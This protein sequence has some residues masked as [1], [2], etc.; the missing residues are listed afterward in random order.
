L[1]GNIG[2]LRNQVALNVKAGAEAYGRTFAIMY[3]ISGYPTATLFSALTNDWSYLVNTQSVTNSPAYLR[4]KGKPVVA[5]WGFGFS[6]RSDTPAQCIQTV[7]WFKSAGCTVMGGVPSYWR[8]LTNDSQTDP[9][10]TNA[11]RSFDIISPWAVGRYSDNAG[12]DTYRTN[13]TVPDLADCSAHG[14]D[15][16]PVVFPGFTW[17]NLNGGASNQI[18]R[19]GGNFYWHQVYNGILSGCS[20]L[21]GAMFDEVDEGTAMF[22]I[23]PTPADQPVNCNFV[24]LNADGYNLPSDWYLRLANEAGKML[25]GDI[26]L[27]STIPISP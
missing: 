15:Y 23:A 2:A 8:T 21:Y 20:M 16:M 17:K 6:G 11:F 4:H 24:P 22:K 26:P 9:A 14:I 7:N 13:I 27:Q 25:R 10:W 19:N 1:S 5:I 12:A 18:P 3:D